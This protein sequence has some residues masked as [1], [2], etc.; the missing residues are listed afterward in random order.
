MGY[1]YVLENMQSLLTSV[2]EGFKKFDSVSVHLYS[3]LRYG[4]CKFNDYVKKCR[5]AEVLYKSCETPSQSEPV[6][7]A[8]PTELIWQFARDM[9]R[10]GGLDEA[11]HQQ[12]QA[13]MKYKKA[14]ELLDHILN[15]PSLS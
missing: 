1:M 10:R 6:V 2:S 3:F 9:G 13:V 14:H 11:I 5:A 8:S 4:C 15:I 7:Q 12:P